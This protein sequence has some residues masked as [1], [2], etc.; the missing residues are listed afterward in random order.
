M[1]RTT[2]GLLLGLA[3]SATGCDNPT[4]AELT[5]DYFNLP[6]EGTFT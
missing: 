2:V 6:D 4:L 1:T 5:A 3:L